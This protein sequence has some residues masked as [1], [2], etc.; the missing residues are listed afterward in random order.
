MCA[1]TR[2]YITPFNRNR[3]R[4]LL[5]TLQHRSRLF[6]WTV[7]RMAQFC[8][9]QVSTIAGDWPCN[10]LF[11]RMTLW[12]C[13]ICCRVA[14]QTKSCSWSVLSKTLKILT[15]SLLGTVLL[16]AR[17]RFNFFSPSF[18]SCGW[19]QIPFRYPSPGRGRASVGRAHAKHV[20]VN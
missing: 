9:I 16:L 15:D 1:H 8:R 2:T 12:K 11:S 10:V 20:A 19:A 7:G 5:P 3:A 13:T 18:A 14:A 17:D 4:P 6:P